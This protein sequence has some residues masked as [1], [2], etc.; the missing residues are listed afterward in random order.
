MNRGLPFG[1]HPHRGFE[2]LTFIQVGELVHTDSGGHASDIRG[3]GVQWMTAGRGLVHADSSSD[4]FRRNGGPVEI[5]QLW[6][7]LPARLKMT[8]P[9]Y[10]GLQREEIP[11]YE[12]SNGHARVNLISGEWRGQRGPVDSLTDVHASTVELR[13]GTEL[14]LPA[15]EGRTVFLYTARGEN[16]ADYR[17]E[18]YA[19]ESALFTPSAVRRRD[20]EFLL[21]FVLRRPIWKSIDAL[22]A[23]FGD[24]N[25][26]NNPTFDYDRSVVSVGV[27]ARY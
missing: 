22:V 26:S 4:E 13:A 15:P 24:F 2:T 7:N 1:P 14:G 16:H 10:V 20:N 8:A 11:S 21:S 12:A 23:Y 18:Y 9:R 17:Y 3:G 19:E 5:L 6:V 25:D 27:E